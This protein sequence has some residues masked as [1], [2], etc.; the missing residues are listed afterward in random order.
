MGLRFTETL[1]SPFGFESCAS[2]R[3]WDWEW[4]E[5]GLWKDVGAALVLAVLA[6]AVA[7]VDSVVE[8]RSFVPRRLIRPLDFW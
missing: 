1:G 8:G 2:D 3:D 6:A 7:V 4:E 5:N